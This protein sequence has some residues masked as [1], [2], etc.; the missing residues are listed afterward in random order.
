MDDITGVSRENDLGEA[1]MS[2][3][4]LSKHYISA[5]SK[6]RETPFKHRPNISCKELE[7]FGSSILDYHKVVLASLCLSPG[8]ALKKIPVAK[9]RKIGC[10]KR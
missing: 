5:A 4:N 2:N 7:V 1:I 9:K 10:P 3:L 8:T 6:A